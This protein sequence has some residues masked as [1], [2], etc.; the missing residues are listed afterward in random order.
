MQAPILAL[1]VFVYDWYLPE[2]IFLNLLLP[3][4]IPNAGQPWAASVKQS[5]KSVRIAAENWNICPFSA[6]GEPN[7]PIE[8]I[9]A[10]GFGPHPEINQ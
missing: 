5:I 7:E 4:C 3:N 9:L 10:D 1:I 2:L 6:G 8:S